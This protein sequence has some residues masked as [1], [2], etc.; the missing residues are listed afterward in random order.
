MVCRLVTVSSYR[1]NVLSMVIGGTVY[2]I[3]R[4]LV[5]FIGLRFSPLCVSRVIREVSQF[6]VLFRDGVRVNSLG[7]VMSN[8]LSGYSGYFSYLGR[9][10]FATN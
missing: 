4:A 7:D 3:F 5:M 10:T 6:S 8:R 1:L 9:V 2:P